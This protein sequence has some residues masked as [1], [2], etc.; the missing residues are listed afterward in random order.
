MNYI[1]S[2]LRANIG[3]IDPEMSLLGV[4]HP[5]RVAYAEPASVNMDKV[6]PKPG[7]ESRFGTPTS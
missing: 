5:Q 1:M 6:A 3:R 2:V 7:N 4:F